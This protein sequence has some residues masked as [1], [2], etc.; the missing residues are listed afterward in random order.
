MCELL[1]DL[2]AVFLRRAAHGF[3]DPVYSRFT[4]LM[5]FPTFSTD[6]LD[7][8]T[9]LEEHRRLAQ[10]THAERRAGGDQVAGSQR[11]AARRMISLTLKIMFF[12]FDFCISVAFM[13][14]LRKL[15]QNKINS[16]RPQ[17][18]FSIYEFYCREKSCRNSVFF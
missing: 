6:T 12:V 17:P 8:V 2:L 7:H 5:S 4:L 15:L 13:N 9:V 18:Y 3:A 16:V 11:R 14:F 10:I 1:L